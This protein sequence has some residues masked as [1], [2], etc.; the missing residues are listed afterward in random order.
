MQPYLREHYC[1]PSAL[2]ATD[3]ADAVH[4]ARESVATLLGATSR[5]IVFT[6]GEAK[7]TTSL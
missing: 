7:Q 3:E 4:D 5:N 1:N 2:Y 6:G